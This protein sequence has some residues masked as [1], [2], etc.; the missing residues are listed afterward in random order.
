MSVAIV[1]RK[2]LVNADTSQCLQDPKGESVLYMFF[3]NCSNF[4]IKMFVA[5]SQVQMFKVGF[6]LHTFLSQQLLFF[7]DS[8]ISVSGF[9]SYTKLIP[10]SQ[11][12]SDLN[13]FNRHCCFT[14][15]QMNP[16]ATKISF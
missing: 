10:E 16:A 9:H 15:F 7:L 6:F 12:K 13:P 5:K 3:D 8:T 11:G 14:S 1:K 4:P 2:I